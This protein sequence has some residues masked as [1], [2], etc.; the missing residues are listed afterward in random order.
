M[1]KIPGKP[2]IDKLRVIHIYEADYNIILK[3]F[4][5]KKTLRNAIKHNAIAPEQAGGHPGRTAI[6]EAIKTVTTYE[7]CNLQRLSG[8]IMYNDTK[9]CFDRIVENISNITCLNA[10]AP[11]DVLHLHHNTLDSMKYIIKH[12]HGLSPL[13]NGHMN[14]D[15]F[16]GV[17][18]GAGNA[19]TRWGFISDM[20]IKAY[21]KKA[22]SAV[23]K[24]AIT[25]IFSNNRVQAF[26]DDSK[27]FIL[28]N[29]QNGQ[30]IYDFLKDNVQL[31]EQ[32]LQITGAKLE[33]PKCK[34]F[35]FTWEFD[36]KGDAFI[37]HAEN[38]TQM[39]IVD[40]DTQLLSTVEA[41]QHDEAYKLL[42][43]QI[44][45]TGKHEKQLETIA[46]NTNQIIKV[47]QKA[48]VAP[49]DL[50]LGFNTIAIPTIYYP[51][52]ASSI[53]SC[54]PKPLKRKLSNTLLPKLGLN[55]TF[56]RA[57]TYAPQY[58]G[59][60]GFKDMEVEYELAHV[61]SIIGHFRVN[62]PLAINYTQLLE[63]FMV[64]AGLDQSPLVDTSEISYVKAPWLEISR[65]FLRRIDGQ[66]HLMQI[67]D[68]PKLR[69]NDR[70][71]M[72]IA[73]EFEFSAKQLNHINQCRTFLQITFVSEMC[74]TTGHQILEYFYDPSTMPRITPTTY[75][76]STISWPVQ[77]NP[78]AASWQT[79]RKLLATMTK[80]QMKYDLSEPLGKWLPSFT[81]HRI[82][83][84]QYS[85][86]FIRHAEI[87]DF[88]WE[89]ESQHLRRQIF[90]ISTS[91]PIESQNHKYLPVFPIISPDN[92]QLMTT[93][94]TSLTNIDNYLH[95]NMP[96][97]ESPLAEYY[98]QI[99]PDSFQQISSAPTIDIYVAGIR[100]YQPQPSICRVANCNQ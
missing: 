28:I 77:S 89:Y 90:P 58:F 41:I 18:Q 7:I 59:G 12:K 26:F 42:G 8:G 27:L 48:P 53:P 25:K 51:F 35:I 14:P 74:S 91:E 16:Y 43:V 22:H 75:S 47:F 45:F 49:T 23:I 20:I 10:G 2:L 96:T 94:Q 78:P 93:R 85:H 36:A 39:N 76:Q 54:Q 9:A 52:A 82:W 66:I 37:S 56:P 81:A 13:E 84:F 92:L 71:I 99:L 11:I 68:L 64:S 24:S 69:E 55:H 63:A 86:P 67:P 21:N 60:L 3:Y 40:T 87:T 5:S 46:T 80:S 44:A 34:F 73:R 97:T 31:W 57:I 62:S 19:G 6:D 17:G 1:E 4:I 83:K 38:R 32:L 50:T 65:N 88:Q 100:H 98:R 79:W 70:N 72:K 33:L 61:M 95:D 29:D 30:T 15:P